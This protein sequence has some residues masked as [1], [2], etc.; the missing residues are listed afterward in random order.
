MREDN[1]KR[2]LK[3]DMLGEFWQHS[4]NIQTV[5]FA[6]DTVKITVHNV[7]CTG[8]HRNFSSATMN[9]PSVDMNYLRALFFMYIT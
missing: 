2:C 1:E 6:A 7:K 8:R 4:F 5:I 3:D 9:F